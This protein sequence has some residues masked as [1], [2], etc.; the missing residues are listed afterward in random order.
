[1]V[2]TTAFVLALSLPATAGA[3]TGE[4]ADLIQRKIAG[5]QERE[6]VSGS[7]DKA[8]G[9][10]VPA[11]LLADVARV[12]LDNGVTASGLASFFDLLASSARDGI[13]TGPLV[14]KVMEGL[15]KGVDEKRITR[16]LRSV[17]GRLAAA[18]TLVEPLSLEGEEREW[19]ILSTA[20]AMAAGMS[21]RSLAKVFEAL[22]RRDGD[23]SLPPGK[24]VDMVK[25]GSGYGVDQDKLVSYTQTLIR[26]KSSDEKDIQRMINDLARA[27]QS[28][29]GGDLDDLVDDERGE[30]D[31]DHD[32]DEDEEE[33][34]D[35][36]GDD[37]HDDKGDDDD[38]GDEGSSEDD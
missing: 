5:S 12:S 4:L 16:A 36:H 25:V 3:V 1:M 21:K 13:P 29:G 22:V 26:N 38:D 19:L 10:G 8:T 20:D 37:D 18:G 11:Q 6:L 14:E 15:A 17:S 34:D 31:D 35:E 27:V 28:G 23:S 30:M 32:E 2:L 7:A 9:D 33:D 24:V